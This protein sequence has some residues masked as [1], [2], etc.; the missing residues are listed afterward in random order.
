MFKMPV[1]KR[2]I[3]FK[4]V[5]ELCDAD[6]AV[7]MSPWAA[8]RAKGPQAPHC[9]VKTMKTL[10]SDVSFGVPSLEFL[11]ETLFYK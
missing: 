10:P 11:G 9:F 5:I 6:E 4:V 3:E 8:T 1:R 7:R 2:T